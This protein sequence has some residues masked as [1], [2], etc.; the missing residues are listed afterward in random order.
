M[1]TQ[2]FS[3]I[4]SFIQKAVLQGLT[5]SEDTMTKSGYG[6]CPQGLWK[7]ENLVGEGNSKNLL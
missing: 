4:H 1:S 2:I 5:G 3:F 6:F 7:K